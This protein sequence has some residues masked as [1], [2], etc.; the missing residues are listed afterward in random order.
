MRAGFQ[1][2]DAYPKER[3]TMNAHKALF[4]L[5]PIGIDGQM[6]AN[7]RVYHFC[8]VE[9]RGSFDGCGLPGYRE[10]ES[11]DAIEGT[12]C[13]QCGTPLEN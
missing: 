13:D 12:V 9:C 10:G 5:E 1:V 6:E 3:M 4:E 7:G 8:S 11:P 2:P